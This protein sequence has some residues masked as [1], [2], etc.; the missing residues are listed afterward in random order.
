LLQGAVGV[1]G[2][3]AG[4]AANTPLDIASN[5]GINPLDLLG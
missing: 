4:D 2:Q 5:L 1:A 3:I